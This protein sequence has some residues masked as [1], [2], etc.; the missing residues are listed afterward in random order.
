MPPTP[1]ELRLLCRQLTSADPQELVGVLQSLAAY[2]VACREA[3][4]GASD[5]AAKGE[6]AETRSLVHKLKTQITSL[7]TGR[8]PEGRFVA[9]CLIKAA[10]D[11]GGWQTLQASEPWIR[12]LLAV[13]TVDMPFLTIASCMRPAN[14]SPQKPNPP[15]SKE[16]AIVALTKMYTLATPLPTLTRELVTPTLKDLIPACLS[17][18]K[19]K[20]T[21]LPMPGPGRSPS[22]KIPFTLTETIL[23]SLT[24]LL[25][26]HPTLFRPHLSHL[27]AAIR[28][29][30]APTISDAA[31]GFPFPIPQP[32]QDAARRL[33][34]ALPATA[35]ERAS[36]TGS[37]GL[38]GPA[39]EWSVAFEGTLRAA[40]MTADGVFRAVVEYGR[41]DGPQGGRAG[42]FPAEP[43]GGGDDGDVGLPTW[44]GVRAGAQRLSGLLALLEAFLLSPTLAAVVVPMDKLM[45]LVARIAF[46][47]PPSSVPGGAQPLDHNPLVERAERDELWAALPGVHLALLR[48]LS[49]WVR[50]MGPNVGPLAP[51][52]LDQVVR[53]FGSNGAVAVL[54]FRRTAY[55]V[56][57]ELLAIIG[58]ALSKRRADSLEP[59]IRSCCRDVSGGGSEDGAYEVAPPDQSKKNGSK[60][61][62]TT[63]N[64]D[65]Y[66][67]AKAGSPTST[68]G[69]LGPVT[70]KAGLVSD[71]DGLLAALVTWLPPSGRN[72]LVQSLVYA[73]AVNAGSKGTLLATLVHPAT[74]KNGRVWPGSTLPYMV[75]RFPDDDVTQVSLYN[76]NTAWHRGNAAR[77]DAFGG[78]VDQQA[79]EL[80]AG[81]QELAQRQR[82]AR[83]VPDWLRPRSPQSA[84]GQGSLDDK[85]LPGATASNE[86][87][88]DAEPGVQSPQPQP[89]ETKAPLQ[90]GAGDGS[91]LLRAFRKRKQMDDAPADST[92]ESAAKRWE[93]MAIGRDGATRPSEGDSSSDESVHLTMELDDTDEDD[94]DDEDA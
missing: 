77:L 94:E 13:V 57:K 70:A 9:V 82:K 18:I 35:P 92:T 48:L 36:G 83:D 80:A 71:A 16:L 69:V 23:S 55:V 3:L 15:Q 78:H 89:P 74:D 65:A 46:V 91:S 50:R 49:A 37:S 93:S 17:L 40:H 33:A 6:E 54:E 11:V 2:V 22:L 30:L 63:Q 19:P 51:Q 75:R 31:P 32:V 67:P 47:V 1:P 38:S 85:V 86:L 59:I 81:R 34:V 72:Q 76:V 21:A 45:G 58:P 88:E 61:S 39:A 7:V 20:T 41:H 10:I 5:G 62:K 8:S 52:L 25:Q 26:L 27:R 12:G 42:D 29:Y 14:T 87:S 24:H 44:R 73:T 28:P 79:D 53:V 68:A 66:L 60:M 90:K 56:V 64:A 4:S 43:S 84:E